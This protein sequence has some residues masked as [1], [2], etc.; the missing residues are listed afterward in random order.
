MSFSGMMESVESLM[1]KW[2]WQVWWV[3]IC[4]GIKKRG[5]KKG[6]RR[7]ILDGVKDKANSAVKAVSGK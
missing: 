2:K 3:L 6:D 7:N 4:A 5:L 1:E